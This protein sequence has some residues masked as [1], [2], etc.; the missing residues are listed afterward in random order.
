MFFSVKQWLL[1][2]LLWGVHRRNLE[3]LIPTKCLRHFFWKCHVLNRGILW[4]L[5]YTVLHTCTHQVHCKQKDGTN[6]LKTQKKHHL[7]MKNTWNDSCSWSK[8]PSTSSSSLPTLGD[9]INI[10]P[11]DSSMKWKDSIHFCF[12]WKKS[13]KEQVSVYIYIPGS[14]R[15]VKFLPFGRFLWWKVINSTHLEDPGILYIYTISIFWMWTNIY[16]LTIQTL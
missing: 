6:I 2:K 12:W 10:Q 8:C 13:C 3:S 1:W 5:Y 16:L 9:S 7:Y 14:S 15:Y 11:S 4:C